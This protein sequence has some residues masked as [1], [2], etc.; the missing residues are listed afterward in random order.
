MN[1]VRASQGSRMN[2]LD[3]LTS[4]GQAMD[5]QYQ[6]SISDLVD[7]DYYSAISQLSKQSVQLEAAQ[8]AFVQITSLGLF[9]L[10]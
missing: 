10:L 9:K 3:S 4:A 7:V 8:K 2:E 1:T 5:T 6:S